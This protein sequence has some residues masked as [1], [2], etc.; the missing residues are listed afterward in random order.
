MDCELPVVCGNDGGECLLVYITLPAEEDALA[1]CRQLV[2][3]GHAAGMN[4]LG[5]GNSVY[6]WQGAMRESREWII[7][8][9]TSRQALQGFK[10][11]ACA[12]HPHVVPCFIAA[13]IAC[14]NP[15]FLEW[16]RQNSFKRP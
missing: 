13:D 14:A 10:D 4:I 3:N 6:M 5:P 15:D 1:F 8:A 12:L 11:A 2:E 9:Q 7:L 16:I